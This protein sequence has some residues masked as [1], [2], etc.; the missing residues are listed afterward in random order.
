MASTIGECSLDTDC[1]QFMMWDQENLFRGDLCLPAFLCSTVKSGLIDWGHTVYLRRI[2]F[3]FFHKKKK[4]NV[5]LKSDPSPLNPTY[6]QHTLR[7]EGGKSQQKRNKKHPPDADDTG[8]SLIEVA[9]AKKNNSDA[10]NIIKAWQAASL[11][12]PAQPWL[13]VSRRPVFEWLLC[14]SSQSAAVD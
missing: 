1:A 3:F 13:S 14:G 8:W 5:S 12:L 10:L 9:E 2:P 11:R 6:T 4:R 7:I